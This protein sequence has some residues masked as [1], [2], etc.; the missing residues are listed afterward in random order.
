MTKK[1][2]SWNGAAHG[3]RGFGDQL[4]FYD[5]IFIFLRL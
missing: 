5:N 3:S 2:C 1:A 4:H